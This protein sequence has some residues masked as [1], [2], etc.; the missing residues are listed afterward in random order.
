[1]NNFSFDNITKQLEQRI[2]SEAKL[3]SKIPILRECISQVSKQRFYDGKSL[4]ESINRPDN[5]QE[6]NTL[7][8]EKME[9]NISNI[10]SYFHSSCSLLGIN[11][12]SNDGYIN[13]VDIV[14]IKTLQSNKIKI[15]IQKE[16]QKNKN[17]KKTIF[18]LIKVDDPQT[19]EINIIQNAIYLFE[20]FF[21]NQTISNKEYKYLYRILYKIRNYPV[22]TCYRFLYT[23]IKQK[24]INKKTFRIYSSL[25]IGDFKSSFITMKY[26]DR[27]LLYSKLLNCIINPEN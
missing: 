15:K 12:Y 19:L 21:F 4:L 27:I 8:I 26:E 22:R 14:E 5:P 3:I 10:N 23:S 20:H 2:N 16:K 1:M 24:K 6:R 9:E 18:D 11:Y 17:T 25:N 13:L 7:M